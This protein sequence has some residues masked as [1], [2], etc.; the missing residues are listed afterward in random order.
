M[1]RSSEIKRMLKH[2]RGM[3]VPLGLGVFDIITINLAYVFALWFR[4]DCRASLIP[5]H[6][7]EGWMESVPLFTVLTD[8]LLA[9]LR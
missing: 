3:L 7:L 1:K 9:L 4:F 6:F 8:T 5:L 2:A